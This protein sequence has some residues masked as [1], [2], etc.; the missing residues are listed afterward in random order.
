MTVRHEWTRRG[1]LSVIQM[2]QGS[3]FL[4]QDVSSLIGSSL[5]GT[6]QVTT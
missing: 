3:L 5:V 1:I 4:Q 6:K 2:V